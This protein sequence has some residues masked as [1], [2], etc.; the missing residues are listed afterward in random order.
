MTKTQQTKKSIDALKRHFELNFNESIADVKK[1]LETGQEQ[2]RE[3]AAIR[4]FICA[5][6]V[7]SIYEQAWR[8]FRINKS[9]EIYNDNQQKGETSEIRFRTYKTNNAFDQ[10]FQPVLNSS[11]TAV[12]EAVRAIMPYNINEMNYV[13]D[14][15]NNGKHIELDWVS[16]QVPTLA[17]RP[18]TEVGEWVIIPSIKTNFQML[19]QNLQFRWS[20]ETKVLHNG[21]ERLK[22]LPNT[23]G[24]NSYQGTTDYKLDIYTT[25]VANHH[26]YC[27]STSD[28][29]DLNDSFLLIGLNIVSS[30][31]EKLIKEPLQYPLFIEDLYHFLLS[32][33]NWIPQITITDG[34][35]YN[36]YTCL[37]RCFDAAKAMAEIT[38][39]Y[40]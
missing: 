4:L 22:M 38:L 28:D 27:Y 31:G 16:N 40:A 35:S 14:T 21:V 20:V 17:N 2:Y 30:T 11:Y 15:S 3:D 13:I 37:R 39:S 6:L 1:Y 25:F 7:R 23:F 24:K 34:T 33:G 8:R 29:P 5:T 10:A 36:P 32:E 18:V 19:N 12:A 9:S 26:V